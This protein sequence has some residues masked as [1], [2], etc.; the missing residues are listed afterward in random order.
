MALRARSALVS[1]AN[2]VFPDTKNIPKIRKHYALQ[3]GNELVSSLPL[4]MLLYFNACYAPFWFL[5]CAIM[6]SYRFSSI[7]FVYQFL[8]VAAYAF[9]GIVESIRLYLGY[10]GN[11]QEKVPELAGFW[12]LTLVIQLPLN[13]FLVANFNTTIVPIEFS[14]N[15]IMSVFLVIEII[16]GYRTI[17][18]ITLSQV[19]KFHL[20]QFEDMSSVEEILDQEEGNQ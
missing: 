10:L 2:T 16:F 5:T 12:L 9:L 20:S 4:Q 8:T 18:A 3:V 15:I 6:F 19:A 1:V 17:R 14:C 13:L 11:L 7:G